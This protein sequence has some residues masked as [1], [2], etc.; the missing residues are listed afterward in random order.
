MNP[1]R[2]SLAC[3]GLSLLGSGLE[4]QTPRSRSLGGDRS[5]PSYVLGEAQECA[6]GDVVEAVGDVDGDG[7]EDV[8]VA[9]PS[10]G[11]NSRD[12]RVYLFRGRDLPTSTI[13]WSA[14]HPTGQS[15][16]R[17]GQFLAGPGDVD[18][19]GLDDVLVGSLLGGTAL[20]L[21]SPRGLD[22]LPAWQDAANSVGAA[23]DV[24]LDGYPDVFTGTFTE[25][26]L[27]HGGPGGLDPAPRVVLPLTGCGVPV[28]AAG[29]GDVD[30]DGYAD[31]A[32]YDGDLSLHRGSTSGLSP[33]PDATTYVESC[34]EFGVGPAGDL[35]GDGFADVVVRRYHHGYSSVVVFG[36]A[37]GWKP[38]A[39]PCCE[40]KSPR[41]GE[42]LALGDADGDG[43]DDL[44]SL[45]QGFFESVVV[46]GSATFGVYQDPFVEVPLGVEL[47]RGVEP[48][49]LW[50]GALLDFTGDGIRDLVVGNPWFR[51]SPSHQPGIVIF[52]EGPNLATSIPRRF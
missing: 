29:V 4:A 39:I 15:G 28:A 49:D 9:A 37:A 7:R 12:G 14:D 40:W 17:F 16:T 34:Y 36:D 43:Y 2:I 3:L 1:R 27:Y 38:L 24:D 21:G 46:F 19:D 47:P 31:V 23:G 5:L 20:H 42:V 22:S 6:F 18:G 26:R 35:N 48:G 33:V 52:Y 30:G 13:G 41:G 8:L 44:L 50:D 32:V 11:A 45:S 51:S 10:W 25:V